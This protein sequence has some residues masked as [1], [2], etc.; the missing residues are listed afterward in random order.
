MKSIKIEFIIS[1][2]IF[3]LYAFKLYTYLNIML[4]AMLFAF[5]LNKIT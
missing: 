4:L 2:I 3:I 5:F 1:L